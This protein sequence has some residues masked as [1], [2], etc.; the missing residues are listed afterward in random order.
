MYLEKSVEELKELVEENGYA[1]G[2]SWEIQHEMEEAKRIFNY[3][4]EVQ[5][6]PEE[7]KLKKSMAVVVVRYYLSQLNRLKYMLPY[8][9][10]VCQFSVPLLLLNEF[11]DKAILEKI[12]DFG[13]IYSNRE[14]RV[15]EQEIQKFITVHLDPRGLILYMDILSHQQGKSKIISESAVRFSTNGY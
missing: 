10:M 5:G 2:I 14:S 13:G 8:D 6:V 9:D 15:L 1:T 4:I 12:K 11:R 7:E 3:L